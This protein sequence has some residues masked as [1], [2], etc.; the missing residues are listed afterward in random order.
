MRTNAWSLLMMFACTATAGV[1]GL[2]RLPAVTPDGNAERASIPAVCRWDL[3]ALYPDEASWAA[4]Y[5]AA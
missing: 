1:G 5:A 3:S 2:D 4:D